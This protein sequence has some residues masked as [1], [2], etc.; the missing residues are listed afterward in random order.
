M[1]PEQQIHT[2]RSVSTGF[3]TTEVRTKASGLLVNVNVSNSYS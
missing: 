2:G 1:L 3:H